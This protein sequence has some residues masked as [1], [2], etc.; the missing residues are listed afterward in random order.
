MQGELELD[1]KGDCY[2]LKVVF[3]A[4]SSAEFGLKLRTHGEEET[5][6]SYRSGD[7]QLRFNRNRSGIGPKGERMTEVELQDDKLS[8]QIL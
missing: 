1:C 6:L 3:E 5:V 7:K 8:L 2:E 4:G